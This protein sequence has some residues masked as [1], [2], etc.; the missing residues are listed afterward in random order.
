MTM[1]VAIIH[2]TQDSILRANFCP[3]TQFSSAQLDANPVRMPS[4]TCGRAGWPRKLSK[5]ATRRGVATPSTT[6]E[7]QLAGLTVTRQQQQ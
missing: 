4:S 3:S 2:T 5:V 7:R 1:L 6:L